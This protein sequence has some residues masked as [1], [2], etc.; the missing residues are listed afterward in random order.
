[1]AVAL[2]DEHWPAVQQLVTVLCARPLP[3]TLSG[4]E[5]ARIFRETLARKDDV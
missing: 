3:A 1:M 2:L 5:A 4:A